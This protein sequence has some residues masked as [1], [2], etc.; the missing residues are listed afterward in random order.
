MKNLAPH[1][2]NENRSNKGEV[3]AGWYA[4]EK[5]GKIVSGPFVSRWDCLKYIAP[6]ST[7]PCDAY[8]SIRT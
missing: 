7:G 4:V 6:I 3:E 5:D 2:L 1:Y 8:A